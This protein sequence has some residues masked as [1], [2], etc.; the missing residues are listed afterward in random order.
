M[1]RGNGTL[2]IDMIKSLEDLGIPIQDK[3]EQEEN[4]IP[5][6]K[7]EVE[8]KPVEKI[9]EKPEE[10]K[11]VQ[12]EQKVDDTRAEYRICELRRLLK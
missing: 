10:N 9:E 6:I 8:E 11:D 1:N 4:V 7:K 3:K 5:E 12:T 2:P